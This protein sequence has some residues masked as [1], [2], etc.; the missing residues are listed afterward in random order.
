LPAVFLS[1]AL[2]LVRSSLIEFSH[3][4]IFVAA[5]LFASSASANFSV[6]DA[7]SLSFSC[8]EFQS[9]LAS[10]HIFDSSSSFF[11]VEFLGLCSTSTPAS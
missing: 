3:Y 4:S 1:V 10:S 6:K 11:L 9:V 7:I 5:C 8:K 2:R